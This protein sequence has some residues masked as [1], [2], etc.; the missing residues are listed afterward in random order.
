MTIL[1]QLKN[2]VLEAAAAHLPASDPHHAPPRDQSVRAVHGPRRWRE[3]PRILTAAAAV[4][5]AAAVTAVL[6]LGA[7]TSP[8][9]AYAL[10]EN[11]D[12][13]IT[14][15]LHDLATAIPQLN[16]K[17]ARLGIEETVIPITS[18]CSTPASLLVT[19]AG[20]LNRSLTLTAG[21]KYLLPGWRGVIAAKQLPGGKVGLIFGAVQGPPPSCFSNTVAERPARAL[22]YRHVPSKA[23][24]AASPNSARARSID[25]ETLLLAKQAVIAFNTTHK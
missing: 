8:Q 6:L 22:G 10:T 7:A 3:Q 5:A 21:R 4:I 16:V 12:G 15:T 13:T 14:V 17:F 25:R 23:G 1:P 11:Q 24:H 20:S 2:D 18:R 19:P 9:P